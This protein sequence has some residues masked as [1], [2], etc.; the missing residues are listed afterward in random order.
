MSTTKV[1]SNANRKII[2]FIRKEISD[3]KER[4]IKMVQ[5]IDQRIVS[6]LKSMKK[7]GG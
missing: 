2:D 3:K 5:S 4:H 1:I 6:S 7:V